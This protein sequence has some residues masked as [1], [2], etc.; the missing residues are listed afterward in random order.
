M[1][2]RD[3]LLFFFYF[4]LSTLFT[5]WF[6]VFS[7][8]YKSPELMILS[9]TIAG[10]KW[11][12]QILGAFLFLKEKAVVFVKNIGFVCFIGSC[13][14]LPFVISAYFGVNNDSN[15][16]ILSLVFAVITMI[17]LYR[18]AVVK[19]Q[20]AISWWYFWLLCLAIA[21]SLQLTVVFKV[22]QF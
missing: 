20:V 11:M 16:F 5:W 12:L 4:L 17:I 18:N 8:D 2:S 3:M 10:A 1:L 7:A 15:F 21:I 13:V 22:I 19:S 14:L 6:V 9:T